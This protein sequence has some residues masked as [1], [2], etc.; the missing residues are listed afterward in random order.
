MT[1]MGRFHWE[2][3]DGSA[4][5]ELCEERQI[6][7]LPGPTSAS[8]RG[9][10]I[11][12]ACQNDTYGELTADEHTALRQTARPCIRCSMLATVDPVFHAARYS[13]RPAYRDDQGTWE[14]WPRTGTWTGIAT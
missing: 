2:D 10:M 13:H 8:E 1:S 14:Y 4:P 12:T 5:G 11:M 6:V 7:N 3:D 9:E